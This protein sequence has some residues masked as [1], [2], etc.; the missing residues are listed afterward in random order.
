MVYSSSG[1][2]LKLYFTY[3]CLTFNYRPNILYMRRPLFIAFLIAIVYCVVPIHLILLA[4]SFDIELLRDINLHRNTSLD[5][6]FSGISN[7]VTPFAVA[8][9]IMLYSIGLIK[10][11]SLYKRNA[12]YVGATIVTS[13]II[14]HVIKNTINRPRPYETYADIDN[15]E[16]GSDP[17]FPSGHTSTAFA[18]ATSLS[19]QYPRWYVI[20][21]SYLWAGTVAYSRLDLGVHYPSDVLV[22]AILGVGSACLCYIINK[23]LRRY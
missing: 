14:T 22:G 7:T 11:D 1:F 13:T 5:P 20:I 17:S 15:A 9:P 18:L 23:N 3:Y 12:I 4:Q 10:S 6:A 16:V 19:L 8:T 2:N 21:P